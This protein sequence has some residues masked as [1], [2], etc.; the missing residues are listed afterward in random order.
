MEY[1]RFYSPR[2]FHLNVADSD[3]GIDLESKYKPIICK[4]DVAKMDL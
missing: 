1:F 4:L 3:I 2:T